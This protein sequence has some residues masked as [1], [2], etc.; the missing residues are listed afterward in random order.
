M[1]LIEMRARERKRMSVMSRVAEGKL[2][3]RMAAELPVAFPCHPRTRARLAALGAPL[4]RASGWRLIEPQ[5][6]L[7]FLKLMMEARVVLSDSGGIQEETTVLGVPC[8]TLRENT[9]RP[10]TV[11]VGTNRLVG[12]SPERIR[13][14]FRA[15]M[16]SAPVQART[17]P[18]WDGKAAGRIADIIVRTIV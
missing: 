14:G 9:E 16:D 10:I 2:K 3:L 1:G 6:Y 12:L 13:E 5:G 11:E 8:L 15:V 17:P 7:E 18:L 4:N